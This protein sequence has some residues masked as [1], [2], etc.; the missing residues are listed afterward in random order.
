MK[1]RDLT[2][3]LQHG[4]QLFAKSLAVVAIGVLALALLGS[5]VGC[6]GGQADDPEQRKN[7]P[8]PDCAMRP[9]ACK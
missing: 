3:M 2:P 5:L 1:L 8:S 4:L 7:E 6:G 9:E